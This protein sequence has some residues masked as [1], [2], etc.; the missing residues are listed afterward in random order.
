MA[1]SAVV[2]QAGIAIAP[3]GQIVGPGSEFEAKRLALRKQHTEFIEAAER[4]EVIESNASATAM[5]RANS[6]ISSPANPMG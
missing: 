3:Q 4:V 2:T 6:G 5:T 1:T